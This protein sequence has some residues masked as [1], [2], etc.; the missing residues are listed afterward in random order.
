VCKWGGVRH[1]GNTTGNTTRVTMTP[2]LH[3]DYDAG[4]D[5]GW[6]IPPAGAGSGIE[7]EWTRRASVR[8]HCNILG[9]VTPL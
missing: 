1:C 8:H 3:Y 6:T 2:L 9:V 7:G 4:N 5:A